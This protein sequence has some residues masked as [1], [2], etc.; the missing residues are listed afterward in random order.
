MWDTFLDGA[1]GSQVGVA[2]RGGASDEHSYDIEVAAQTATALQSWGPR[3]LGR[4]LS[5]RSF[6]H[7]MWRTNAPP[8]SPK[9][10]FI[11]D[12]AYTEHLQVV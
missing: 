3:H 8:G 2:T 6:Y 10:L 1:P 5:G 7:G 9:I 4:Q 12:P 11:G